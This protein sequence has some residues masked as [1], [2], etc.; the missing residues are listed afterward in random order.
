MSGLGL[1]VKSTSFHIKAFPIRQDSK[2]PFSLFAKISYAES[3]YSGGYID[4]AD[5]LF[6]GFS[7]K[8]QTIGVS[9]GAAH[10]LRLDT[11]SKIVGS[12]ELQNQNSVGLI[13]SGDSENN[14]VNNYSSLDS[15]L[16]YIYE[17]DKR[18]VLGGGIITKIATQ[19]PFS[20]GIGA[21]IGIKL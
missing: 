5:E 7:L 15:E 9:V 20:W 10:E 14:S 19:T 21:A 12:V 16:S 3:K 4:Y 13:E 17:A 2:T 8:E 11:K 1:D 6:D 18:I